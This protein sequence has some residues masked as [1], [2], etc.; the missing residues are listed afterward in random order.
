MGSTTRL[1]LWSVLAGIV[2]LVGAAL[3]TNTVKA[4]QNLKA[5]QDQHHAMILKNY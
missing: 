2:I 4:A 5:K 3:I 1:V